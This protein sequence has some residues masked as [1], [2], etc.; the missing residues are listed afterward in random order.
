VRFNSL[1]EFG[2][3]LEA[4]WGWIAEAFNS[5]QT[6]KSVR[7]FIENIQTIDVIGKQ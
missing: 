3:F 6:G 4:G 5:S 1:R 7:E 2:N